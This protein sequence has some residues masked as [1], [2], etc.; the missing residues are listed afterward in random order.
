MRKGGGGRGQVSGLAADAVEEGLVGLV[1]RLG[2]L[3]R[4]GRLRYL[5]LFAVI[6]RKTRTRGK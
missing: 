6:V 2:L 5:A 1:R 4:W 3:L